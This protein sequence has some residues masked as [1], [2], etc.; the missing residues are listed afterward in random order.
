LR[1]V[2]LELSVFD[3]ERDSVFEVYTLRRLYQKLYRLRRA[4]AD[5]SVPTPD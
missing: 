2:F 1:A 5:P 3:R 4:A